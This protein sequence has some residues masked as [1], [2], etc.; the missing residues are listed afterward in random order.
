MFSV[1]QSIGCNILLRFIFYFRWRASSWFHSVNGGPFFIILIIFN[2]KWKSIF[3]NEKWLKTGRYRV[4]TMERIMLLRVHQLAPGIRFDIWVG[5][6]RNCSILFFDG[7]YVVFHDKKTFDTFF[8]EECVS[9][10]KQHWIWFIS[11][12]DPLFSS[13][14]G[15][16][17]INVR[18]YTLSKNFL[19]IFGKCI[20]YDSFDIKLKNLFFINASKS[21][22]DLK[23]ISSWS[24][25]QPWRSHFK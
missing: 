7:E 4:I 20:E 21:H 5:L 9:F 16:Y 24:E 15:R 11:A 18:F 23:L 6:Q 3:K 8:R 25:A 13:N 19:L 14:F 17:F 2:Q 1:L 12:S 22:S 10:S